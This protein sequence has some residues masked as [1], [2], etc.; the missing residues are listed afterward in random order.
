MNTKLADVIELSEQSHVPALMA[1]TQPDEGTA[2][3][4]LYR[5][6]D[7]TWWQYAREGGFQML[8]EVELFAAI[9]HLMPDD[10]ADAAL[11]QAA[12]DQYAFD[13]G[14]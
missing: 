13:Y 1:H 3:S 10:Q 12:R 14:D 8:L 11:A 4:C 2:A 5:M 6:P 7:G 9:I